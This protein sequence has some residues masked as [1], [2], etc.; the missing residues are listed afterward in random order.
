MCPYVL[1]DLDGLGLLL[2]RR[3]VRA[4]AAATVAVVVAR[5]EAVADFVV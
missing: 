5:K 3:C 1:L 4:T 2:V